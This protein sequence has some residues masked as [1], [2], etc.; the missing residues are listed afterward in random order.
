MTLLISLIP[1]PEQLAAIA[2]RLALLKWRDGA[3]TAG[4]AARAVKHN[5]QAVMNS[6][7]ARAVAAEIEQALGDHP[8]LRAAALPRRFSPLMISQ[9]R[10]GGH[11][12]LHVDNAVMKGQRGEAMRSDLSFTLFLSGAQDY[13]GGELVIH[14]PGGAQEVKGEAGELVLYP[15]NALHEVR[16]V[17]Q[18]TRMVCVGWIESMVR[19]A[20]QR[21]ILFDLENLRAGLR[22]RLPAQS[23]ELLALDKTIA[24][25]LRRWASV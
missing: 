8:V 9:T 22:S 16:K 6:T 25:L 21:E 12:G 17:T 7:A 18:G 15:A 2:Q 3:A 4:P 23:A 19:D 10:D 1:D 14:S 5:L 20:G 11:Y 24:N 13:E